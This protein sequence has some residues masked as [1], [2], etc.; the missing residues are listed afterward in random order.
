MLGLIGI[1]ANYTLVRAGEDEAPINTN[2]PSSQFNHAI[3]FVPNQADTI[4]LECTSQTNP[5]GYMGNH[6]GDRKALAITER[7]AK[8]VS[9]PR[10]PYAL[11]VQSRTSDVMVDAKGNAKA[12]V[13]TTYSGT[14]YENGGLDFIANYQHDDQLKWVEKNTDIPS[15]N[16]A[17]F[18]ITNHKSRIPSATVDL[19][20]TLNRLANVTG[21]RLFLS[22]NLM[23]RFNYVP[24]KVENRKSNVLLSSQS[25]DYDTIRFQVPEEIYPEFLPD[26][27]FLKTRFG[28]YEASFKVDQGKVIYNR[29]MVLKPG[30]FPPESYKEL[31]E[32]F[33]NISKADNIKLVF[34]TKT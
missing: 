18:K 8:I 33:K 13:R 11:N 10:Y 27:V 30:E 26:P 29:R 24:E 17:S 23:N 34:L 9:T 28:E 21:K 7:G 5:F 12:K 31:I 16:I 25:T 4:W 6:T 2:F 32:F 19:D 20:L 22:P 1:K 15:F 14:Q 3:V